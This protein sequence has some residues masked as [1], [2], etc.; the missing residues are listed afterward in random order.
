VLDLHRE[1][2]SEVRD[3]LT[4]KHAPFMSQNGNINVTLKN[5]DSIYIKCGE[6]YKTEK[7]LAILMIYSVT[8]LL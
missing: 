6:K 5:L 4:P 1:Q 8:T 7:Q 2:C 3:I